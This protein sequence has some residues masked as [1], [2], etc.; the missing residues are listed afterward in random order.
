[1][2]LL[3]IKSMEAAAATED[4]AEAQAV[5]DRAEANA[6]A[7][8]DHQGRI[9]EIKDQKENWDEAIE[10]GD[11]DDVLNAIIASNNDRVPD[12]G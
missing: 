10:N 1:M 6:Q 11:S 4:A 2:A 8:A 12:D 7:L 5:A 9:D 3:K